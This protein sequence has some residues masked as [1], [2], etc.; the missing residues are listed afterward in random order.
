MCKVHRAVLG[1]QNMNNA[2]KWMNDYISRSALILCSSDWWTSCF[3]RSHMVDGWWLEFARG[4]GQPSDLGNLY[5]EFSRMSV[6]FYWPCR[7][8]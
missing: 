1:I 8:Y 5:E 6:F 3:N 7:E 2:K 4:I